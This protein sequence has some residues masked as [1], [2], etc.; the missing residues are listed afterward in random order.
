VSTVLT[1]I[2]LL[3]Y[4]AAR[5]LTMS[6]RTLHP[7]TRNVEIFMQHSEC[8]KEI[9]NFRSFCVSRVAQGCSLS[10]QCETIVAYKYNKQNP[11]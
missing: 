3:A 11:V 1:D 9:V 10:L 8:G 5:L 6:E 7:I 2:I 4:V